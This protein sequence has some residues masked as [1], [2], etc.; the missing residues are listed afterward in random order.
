LEVKGASVHGQAATGVD[1]CSKSSASKQNYVRN[2][3]GRKWFT[4]QKYNLTFKND[5]AADFE[6][7]KAYKGFSN[8]NP[9]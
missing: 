3:S 4:V 7:N 9:S 8:L 2:S 1:E 5:G 6:D